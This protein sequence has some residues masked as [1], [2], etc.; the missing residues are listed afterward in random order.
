MKLIPCKHLNFNPE[1]YPSCQLVR[2]ETEDNPNL[3]CWKRFTPNGEIQYCQFCDKRGRIY[4]LTE[5]HSDEEWDCYEPDK[6][7]EWLR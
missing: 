5:C 3:C 1:D 7:W 4:R 6:Q 2:M